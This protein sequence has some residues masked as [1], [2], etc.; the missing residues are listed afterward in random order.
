MRKVIFQLRLLLSLVFIPGVLLAQGLSVSYGEPWCIYQLKY[1]NIELMDVGKHI[2]G[3]VAIEAVKIIKKGGKVVDQWSSVSSPS[4]NPVKKEYNALFNGMLLNCS[5]KPNND[6]LLIQVTITNNTVSDTLGG[7]SICPLILN[8]GVKPNNLLSG[9]PYYANNITSPAVL[10]AAFNNYKLILENSDMSKK[11]YL[12]LMEE[13][14]FNGTVYRVWTGTYPYTGMRDF[15][16]RAALRLAPGK[17]FS[18]SIALKFCKPNVSGKTIASKTFANFRKQNPYNNN[19]TDRRPVGELFLSSYNSNRNNQNPRNWSYF[20]AKNTNLTS[21]EGIQE[22][23][24]W[25]MQYADR[26]VGILKD[27]GAQGMITWDIEGQEYPHN[28]SYIGDPELLAKLSPEMNALADEYFKKFTNA[29]LRTGVCVRPD[30]IIIL[31]NNAGIIRVP[32]KDPAAT[33]IRKIGY[34]RKRWGCTLFYIDSN[35]EPDGTVMDY[36]IFKKVHEAFP[37]VLL[38]PE[39]ERELY[40]SC[41]AP[42]EELHMGTKPLSEQITNIYPE[43]FMMLS[44]AEALPKNSSEENVK[45]LSDI[46][47]QGNILLFRAWFDEQPIN[48]NIKRAMK[49]AGK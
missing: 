38:A 46:I 34:A 2:G 43:A 37:D 33:L 12:G 10:E 5:F 39:H 32:V 42:Y 15:D 49:M 30:S 8:F 22:L 27:V 31:K 47:K 13:N 25:L 7:V 11:V 28:L 23:R 45:L 48:G 6:T 29:G 21:K 17:S 1:N 16:Q 40:Y 18:Y 44:V 20:P 41:S 14:G 19:W 35:G 9:Y 24:T 36:R 4:Y 3:P 26:S